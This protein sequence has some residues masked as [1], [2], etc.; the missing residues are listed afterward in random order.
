M[1]WGLGAAMT[2]GKWRSKIFSLPQITG[3]SCAQVEA[4]SFVD[5]AG[6]TVAAYPAGQVCRI[7]CDNSTTP[8]L[9]QTLTSRAPFRL[10]AV[11]GRD[12]EIELD[13]KS[14]IFNVVLAQAMSEIATA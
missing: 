13:V 3:F 2:T 12:W 4:Q 6:N 1:K 8:I 9:T 11:Q 10:P 5:A 14:E 7:Y